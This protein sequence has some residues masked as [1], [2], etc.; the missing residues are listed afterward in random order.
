MTLLDR[1]RAL[2]GWLQGAALVVL[3]L[4]A[5]AP[6]LANG[7]VSD[8]EFYIRGIQELASLEGLRDIWLRLGAV[9]QYYPLVH[10]AFWLEYRLWGLDPVGFHA[11][12]LATHAAVVLLAW[13]LL[14]RLA[15]PGA[16]LAAAVF[17]VH[18]V[19]VETVAWASERKNLL[20]MAFALGSLLAYLRFAPL[21]ATPP[22]ARRR[23]WYAFS[24]ALYAAALLCKT[25]VVT[26]PAVLGVL[27]W[28]K[29]GRIERRHLRALAPFLA[30]GVPLALVTVWVEREHVG[31]R[32]VAFDLG[33]LDRVL[34]AGRAIWFYFSKLAWPHPLGFVYPRWDVDPRDVRQWIYPLGLAA[35]GALLLLARA[36]IGR[37][38]LAA[39]LL[40][41]GILFPALG[42]FDVYPFLFSFVADH[43]QYHAS[44]API[45]LAA[46]GAAIALARAAPPAQHAGCAALVAALALLGGIAHRET[47]FYRDD[48]TLIRRSVEN[49]PGAWSARFRMAGLLASDHRY[50]EAVA[51]MRE[52]LA[53]FPSHAPMHVAIAIYLTELGRLDEAAHELET[54]L[55]GALD[56]DDRFAIW[57]RLGNLRVVQRRLDA[58]APAFRAA[59]ELAPDSAEAHYALGLV[60]RE[61]GDRAGALAALRR[62][63]AL[64]AGVAKSQYAL[65]TVLLEAGDADAA[66][67]PLER[68]LALEPSHAAAA[69][70]LARARTEAQP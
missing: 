9:P 29:H 20:S 36:R 39:L 68:A 15:L 12:N 38:P 63:V 16:W 47:R 31:A 18:P 11:M 64:D 2:P 53:L 59:T 66:I 21:D 7:Y 44:L 25:V 50:E 34:I 48:E 17:A 14:R 54:A 6:S 43:Y 49:Q 70:S 32:G 61:T 5:H 55:A 30:I 46:A 3:A 41:A 26:T 13:S 40:F 23:C 56:P 37:G 67:A 1:A 52:A 42:F 4:A 45:A 51:E 62:S 10:T 19:H 27:V 33:P 35:L 69:A 60:L 8:D 58:A 65:G 22:A 57:M 28:W 24:L